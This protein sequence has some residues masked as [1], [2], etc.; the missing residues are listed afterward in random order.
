M[1]FYFDGD[2]QREPLRR[3]ERS[4]AKPLHDHCQI[5]TYFFKALAKMFHYLKCHE[6]EYRPPDTGISYFLFNSSDFALFL[7]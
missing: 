2:T 7:I 4:F 1:L 5:Y 3:R 6:M